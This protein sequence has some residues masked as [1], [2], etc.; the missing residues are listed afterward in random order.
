MNK[1]ELIGKKFIIYI[2]EP[3]DFGTEHGCGPFS[4]IL[5]EILNES[6]ENFLM[7]LENS[8]IYKDTTISR[9][10]AQVRYVGKSIYDILRTG[11]VT[12][13]METVNSKNIG[14]IGDIEMVQNN[15]NE[16]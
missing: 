5:D 4:V 2:S 14:F 15:G 8:I 10:S 16:V 13:G 6:G 9:I 12:I 11:S 1:S 7:H 3:W